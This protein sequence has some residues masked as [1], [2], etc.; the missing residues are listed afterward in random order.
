MSAATA[1]LGASSVYFTERK[2][3]GLSCKRHQRS[4]LVF[5]R[6]YFDQKVGPFSEG[7][8][9]AE[10]SILCVWFCLDLNR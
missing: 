10:N 8:V 5:F 9:R 6:L 2:F 1:R 7:F 3:S 4:Y